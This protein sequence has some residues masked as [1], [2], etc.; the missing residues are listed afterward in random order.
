MVG[1]VDVVQLA[2]PAQ[3]ASA[4]AAAE[5][6][7]DAAVTA[8]AGAGDAGKSAYEIWLDAGNTGTEVDFLNSLKGQAGTSAALTGTST[9]STA[10]AAGAK[11]FTTQAGLAIAVGQFVRVASTVTPSTYMA[12]VVTSYSGTS[13]AVDV[14]EFNGSGTLNAWTIGL[15][16][17]RGLGAAA[18]SSTARTVGLGAKAFTVAAGLAISPGML[19]R[20]WQT[21]N[22]ANYMVGTV[23]SYSGTTLT[24]TVT[25]FGGTGNF[26]DWTV[27]PNGVPGTV[28]YLAIFNAVGEIPLDFSGTSWPSRSSRIIAVTGA[29]DAAL[30]TGIVRYRSG[31]YPGAPS[32]TDRVDGDVWE[33]ELS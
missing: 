8:A 17:P 7:R 28:D 9:T 1:I 21:S 14:S 29:S 23:A 6:A 26:S 11:T 30:F 32:P 31:G 20:A 2:T 33:R 12:G 4:V 24:L 15:S 3:L 13:L 27:A 10:V 22:P 18:V 25:S 19:M 16:A 5:A